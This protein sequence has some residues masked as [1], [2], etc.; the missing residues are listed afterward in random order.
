MKGVECLISP[1]PAGGRE[2]SVACPECGV[3][4]NHRVS[5][6]TITD[7]RDNVIFNGVSHGVSCPS[8]KSPFLIQALRA[9]I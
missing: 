6:I 1:G 7:P 5:A 3:S 2:V 9:S 8:C 4:S